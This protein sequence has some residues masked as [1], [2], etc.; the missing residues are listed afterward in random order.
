M[1][2]ASQNRSRADERSVTL[3]VSVSSYGSTALVGAPSSRSRHPS[4]TQMV[5]G[6][7]VSSK[8]YVRLVR[9]HTERYS[10]LYTPKSHRARER[11]RD[12]AHDRHHARYGLALADRLGQQCRVVGGTVVTRLP[13]VLVQRNGLSGTT[14]SV[15][16]RP[17]SR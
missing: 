6:L 10:V 4:C 17:P 3:P 13:Y 1:P 2:V 16:S 14:T 8:N 5:L 12:I 11:H 15:N 7:V 9:S